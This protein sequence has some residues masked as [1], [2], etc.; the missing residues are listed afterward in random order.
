MNLNDPDKV[1]KIKAW[2]P[3]VNN[4]NKI[5][6]IGITKGTKDTKTATTSSSA[7]ILPNS[8]KLND[9]GFVKS[10]KTLIGNNKGIG[11]IYFEK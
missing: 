2:I 4:P 6:G 8:L 10:S 7:K 1:A 5:K 11:C 3:L 9:K